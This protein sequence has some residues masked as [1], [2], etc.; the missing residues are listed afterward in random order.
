MWRG[1][2]SITNLDEQGGRPL[3]PSAE[4]AKAVPSSKGTHILRHAERVPSETWLPSATRRGRAGRTSMHHHGFS[5]R[6][7]AQQTML[8]CVLVQSQARTKQTLQTAPRGLYVHQTQVVACCLMEGHDFKL[9]RDCQDFPL[10][11]RIISP[12]QGSMRLGHGL[13]NPLP[14]RNQ[15]HQITCNALS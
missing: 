10:V 7:E 13:C 15:K 11:S 6:M 9:A 3:T 2:L 5:A 14:H 1:E 8:W 12:P 4:R